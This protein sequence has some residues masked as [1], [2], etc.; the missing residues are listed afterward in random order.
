MGQFFLIGWEI[1]LFRC[2][3][4]ERVAK[5]VLRGKWTAKFC[6]NAKPVKFPQASRMFASVAGD[7]G[8]E[9]IMLHPIYGLALAANFRQG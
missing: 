3:N 2:F 4:L 7:Y 1:S 8:V 9:H 6:N 5:E